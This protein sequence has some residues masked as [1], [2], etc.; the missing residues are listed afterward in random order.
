MRILQPN[1]VFCVVSNRGTPV[2]S[3]A[4]ITKRGFLRG[5]KDKHFDPRHYHIEVCRLEPTGMWIDWRLE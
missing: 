3:T 4:S 5:L 1:Q 2:P